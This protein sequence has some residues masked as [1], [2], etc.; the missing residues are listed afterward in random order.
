MKKTIYI[1]EAWRWP[2]AWPVYVGLVFPVDKIDLSRFND[3]KKFSPSKR[4]NLYQE[5]VSL[6]NQWNLVFASGS[7]DNLEIDKFWIS[8]AIFLAICRWIRQIIYKYYTKIFQKKLESS[9]DG[10]DFILDFKI[11]QFLSVKSIGL[12]DFSDFLKI[13]NLNF[14]LDGKTDYGLKKNIDLKITTVIDGDA[15]NKNIWMASIVAKVERDNFMIKV[16]EL[17]P[18]YKL[19]KHKWYWTKLHRDL[20]T[21]YWPSDFH[22]ISFLQNM[23]KQWIIFSKTLPER[24]KVKNISIL[25]KRDIV[26]QKQKL[27]LH[28]CCAPDLTY[29]IEFLQKYFD[30]HI[31]W[32]NPNVSDPM[33]HKKR[34]AQYE[35]LLKIHNKF[36]IFDVDYNP[37]EFF[38]YLYKNQSKIWFNQQEYK[39]FIKEISSIPEWWKRCDLCYLQRLDKS[40]EIAQKLWI[41][42][43][44]TTLSISPH[45]DLEKLKKY[46]IFAGQKNNVNFLFFDFRKNN[47]FQHSLQLCRQ[48]DIRR[49]TYCGCIWSKK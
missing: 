42:Y 1:D 14:I 49:Q 2:F 21:N 9:N 10:D 35:K 19:E 8:A 24:K 37:E 26:P 38:D 36:K 22:R 41:K 43:F 39:N 6:E 29:P 17:Y 3:S 44:T 7:A 34:F 40:A 20:I 16:S 18:E 47:G 48:F 12:K 32:Y 33:E 28:V 30:L 11:R 45:K 27:L 13:I 4:E 25:D 15:K 46:W 5:I 23:I 31:F